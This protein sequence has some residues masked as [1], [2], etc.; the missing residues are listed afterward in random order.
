MLKAQDD[1]V[2]IIPES[3]IN[4]NY[5]QKERLKSITIL[6][7]NPFKDTENPVCVAC[8]DGKKKEF[9]KIDIYKNDKYIIL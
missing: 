1:V 3:F 6:E 4:S 9:D 2:A 8:F 5:K 7:E